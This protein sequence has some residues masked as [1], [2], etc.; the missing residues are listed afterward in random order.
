[1]LDESRSAKRIATRDA[2]NIACTLID[3]DRG[4]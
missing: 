3:P 2:L 4:F 1:M